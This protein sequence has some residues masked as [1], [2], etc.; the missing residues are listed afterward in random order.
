MCG[1]KGK[2]QQ[3]IFHTVVFLYKNVFLKGSYFCPKMMVGKGGIYSGNL[4]FKTKVFSCLG[5]FTVAGMDSCYPSNP[6]YLPSGG[7]SA[8]KWPHPR[9]FHWFTRSQVGR[10]LS[11]LAQVIG[12]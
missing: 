3:H 11:F 8:H 2:I 9:S 5:C 6:R 4:T 12:V 7:A 1:T 10:N